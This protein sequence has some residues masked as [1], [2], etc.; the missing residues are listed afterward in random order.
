MEL[1]YTAVGDYELPDL[2]VPEAP[3]V[4]KYGRMYLRYLREQRDGIYTG[5]LFSGKLKST[6]EQVDRDAEKLMQR[7]VRDMAKAQSVTEALKAADQMAWV[8]AMNNIRAAA[9]EIVLREV[10]FA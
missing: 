5:L 4:G 10:V 9:E 1:S 7:L 8:G 2:A 6:A 3:K